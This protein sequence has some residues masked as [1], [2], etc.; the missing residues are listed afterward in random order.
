M[1]RK[2]QKGGF[3]WWIIPLALSS[4]K[5]KKKKEKPVDRR[6]RQKAALLDRLVLNAQR[7]KERERRMQKGK[8]QKDCDI[9]HDAMKSKRVVMRKK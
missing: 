2:I 6:T 7:K 5:K 4:S 1:E 3:V 9:I 8:G